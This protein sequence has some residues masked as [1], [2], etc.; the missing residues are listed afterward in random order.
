MT[1]EMETAMVIAATAETRVADVEM[2]M[3]EPAVLQARAAVAMG[4]VAR[5]VAEPEAAARAAAELVAAA[6]AAVELVTAAQAA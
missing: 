5:A 6:Q 4:M 2:E 1:V 3:G